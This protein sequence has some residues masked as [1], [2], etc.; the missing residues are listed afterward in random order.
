MGIPPD[1]EAKIPSTLLGEQDVSMVTPD[2]FRIRDQLCS[3][4]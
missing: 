4:E 2:N 1:I 3:S